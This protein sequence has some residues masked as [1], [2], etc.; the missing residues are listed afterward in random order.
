MVCGDHPTPAQA[1]LSEAS[2]V[3][4]V[5]HGPQALS[6]ATVRMAVTCRL[7]LNNA[8]SSEVNILGEVQCEA[9]K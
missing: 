6:I 8:L 1:K 9:G 5:D 7:S 2:L 3:S 4:A